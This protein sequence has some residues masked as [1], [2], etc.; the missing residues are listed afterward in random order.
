MDTSLSVIKLLSSETSIKVDKQ[1]K[2]DKHT[3][4]GVIYCATNKAGNSIIRSYKYTSHFTMSTINIVLTSRM[5]IV[6]IY[7]TLVFETVLHSFKVQS[8]AKDIKKT[9]F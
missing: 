5:S 3:Q 4:K 1:L 6:V 9:I 7:E 2:Y 8:Q